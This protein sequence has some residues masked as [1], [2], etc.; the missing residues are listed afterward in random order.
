MNNL[1]EWKDQQEIIRQTTM[2]WYSLGIQL[3]PQQEKPVEITFDLTGKT[4]GKAW[5]GNNC[6]FFRIEY[7]WQLAQENMDT[8]L[9]QTVPHEVAHI[10]ANEFFKEMWPDGVLHSCLWEFVMIKFGKVPNKHHHYDCSKIRG[11]KVAQV[12]DVE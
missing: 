1:L 4:S 8:F 5:T 2:K 3:F 6:S 7:N 10:I 12:V 11:N 9:S